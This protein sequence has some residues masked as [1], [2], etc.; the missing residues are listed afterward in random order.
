MASP[1]DDIDFSPYGLGNTLREAGEDASAFGRGVGKIGRGVVNAVGDTAQGMRSAAQPYF[2]NQFSQMEQ[3]AGS[4]RQGVADFKR[5]LS[6]N[7]GSQPTA[8]PTYTPEQQSGLNKASEA[9]DLGDRMQRKYFTG[10]EGPRQQLPSFDPGQAPRGKQVYNTY[11]PDRPASMGA[12]GNNPWQDMARQLAT[13]SELRNRE[14]MSPGFNSLTDQNAIDNDEKTRR[15]AMEDAARQVPFAQ[16]GQAMLHAMDSMQGNQTQ[17]RGQDI[18]AANAATGAGLQ[19]RGQDM[20][21]RSHLEGLGLQGRNQ[22]DLANIHGRNQQENTRLGYNLQGDN[23]EMHDLRSDESAR[24]LAQLRQKLDVN[25]PLKAAQANESKSRARLLG[26]QADAADQAAAYDK[27]EMGHLQKY[28][29]SLIKSGMINS[30]DD[31]K[32]AEAEEAARLRASKRLGTGYADGGQVETPEQL[33][34][35]IQAKYGVSGNA[36]QQQAPTPAPQPVRQQA[37]PQPTGGLMDRLR[38]TATG[39]LDRRMQAAGFAEGGPI[40]VGGRSVHGEGDGKSD[41]LPAVIDGEHPAALSS[42]EFVM[43]VEAVRHFGLDRLNKM[44]A[45]ARKGLDTG[46]ESA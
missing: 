39:G 36:P 24:G 45:V 43:P 34:A 8:Q 13:F 12:P 5:G 37:Q 14:P 3:Q 21:L 7:A 40:A 2:D 41:S 18:Q 29:D 9:Q 19:A 44:V 1:Y 25:D 31:L 38:S 17:R 28:R 42:G 4:F 10:L 15:W 27:T 20:Q 46:R 22:L 33:M 30:L 26:T 11:D 6:G 16:R 23:Q 32:R 35:R